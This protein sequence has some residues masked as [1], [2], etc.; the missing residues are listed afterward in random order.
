MCIDMTRTPRK[1]QMP[2]TSHT[3]TESKI[4]MFLLSLRRNEIKS[5]AAFKVP[6]KF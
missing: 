5:A 4:G 1:S 2:N 6:P 3:R